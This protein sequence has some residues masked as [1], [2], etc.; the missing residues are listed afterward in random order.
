MLDLKEIRLLVYKNTYCNIT[1]R[2]TV[3]TNIRL[4][5]K[6]LFIFLLIVL[7]CYIS[8]SDECNFQHIF[9]LIKKVLVMSLSNSIK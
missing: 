7:L 3:S 2:Q 9:Q 8:V 1:I 6:K 5:N 4:S